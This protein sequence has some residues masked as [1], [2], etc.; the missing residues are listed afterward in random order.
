MGN[1]IKGLYVTLSIKSSYVALGII[2]LCHNVMLI[3]A[4]YLL[5]Y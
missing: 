3:V 1:S 2:M 5:L 4:F